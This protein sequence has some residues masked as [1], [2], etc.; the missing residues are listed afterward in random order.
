MRSAAELEELF[1]STHDFLRK[2]K[3]QEEK[4]RDGEGKEKEEG[5]EGE[6]TPLSSEEGG[7]GS[8]AE[9]EGNEGNDG[10]EGGDGDEGKR[11]KEGE[12]GEWEV[13]VLKHEHFLGVILGKVVKTCLKRRISDVCFL[14]FCPL[15]YLIPLPNPFSPTTSLSHISCLCNTGRNPVPTQPNSSV[16]YPINCLIFSRRL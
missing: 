10:D 3:N 11:G 2:W 8:D 4:E 13:E 5:A 16:Y 15:P 9:R 12:E 6:R 7:E 14:F 1:H